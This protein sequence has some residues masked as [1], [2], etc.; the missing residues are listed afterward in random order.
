MNEISGEDVLVAVFPEYE[1]DKHFDL[2]EIDTDSRVNF[3]IQTANLEGELGEIL[4][5]E[6]GL[7]VD[8]EMT[9][10]HEIISEESG[11]LGQLGKVALKSMQIPQSVLRHLGI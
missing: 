2:P 9:I 3:E 7:G 1:F 11:L 4:K 6:R 8:P 5:L 10:D